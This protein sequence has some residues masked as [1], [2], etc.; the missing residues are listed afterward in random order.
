M[1]TYKTSGR[2]RR[3]L[4]LGRRWSL[5]G[6]WAALSF[7]LLPGCQ[8]LA[9]SP[10]E[11]P[12][13]GQIPLEA[14]RTRDQ[15]GAF[16]ADAQAAGET[17]DVKRGTL[18][19]VIGF[20][21]Q[22]VPARTAKLSFRTGGDVRTVYVRSGQAVKSGE[23]LAQLALDDEALRTAQTQATVAEL[24]YQ[25]QASRVEQL[26]QG[27]GAASAED[28]RANVAKARA[29]LLEAQV[30]RDVARSA[31][32]VSTDVQLAS[33]AVDQAKD[34]LANA[35]DVSRRTQETETSNAAVAVRT[36]QRRVDEANLR[37]ELLRAN[38][39]NAQ[40]SAQGQQ[41]QAQLEV[42]AAKD[43][44]ARAQ[45]MAG[46]GE[47]D[48]RAAPANAQAAVQAAQ[49][50]VAA[51]TLRLD[52]AQQ[53]GAPAN[54]EAAL[55]LARLD[56]AQA[57]AQRAQAQQ[58]ARPDQAAPPTSPNLA[59]EVR[60]SGTI[61]ALPAPTPAVGPSPTPG[62]VLD[63]RS[64]D[65]RVAAAAQKVEALSRAPQ[66]Q[67]PGDEQQLAQLQL[68]A[69]QDQLARAQAA[70]QQTAQRT[71]Q[72]DQTGL[73]AGALAVRA[74]DRR[75]QDATLRLQ[76]VQATASPTADQTANDPEIRL[77]ELNLAQAQDDLTAVQAQAN[78]AAQ[79]GS[80]TGQASAA[81]TAFAVRAA[82]RKL[83]EATLKLQQAGA[84]EQSAQASGD[85]QQGVADLRVAAAQ[86][87]LQAAQA[88]LN[89]VQSGSGSAEALRN[90][91]RRAELLQSE[92][93]AA[94]SQAQPVITL[95]AP[96]DGT[97]ASVDVTENQT[98]DP[99][100]TV[101]RL[102]DP[103]RLSVLA[104][105]SQFEVSRLS[106]D[107]PVM[108]DFPG[109][110]SE[111]VKGTIVDLST[112]AVRDGDRTGFPV[113][114][115]LDQMP[116]AVR[117]GMTA[118][119]NVAVKADNVLYVPAAA[120]HMVGASPM[121]TRV[122]PDGSRQD[123]QVVLGATFGSNIEIVSGLKEQDTIAARSLAAAPG[124]RPA[125]N[126]QAQVPTGDAV[127]SAITSDTARKAQ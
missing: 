32:P 94:R 77:A 27:G 30:A 61:I 69:A 41:Q 1:A 62:A 65:L 81:S 126:P 40:A 8:F 113:R 36:A 87:S 17:T 108:I 104:S 34:E 2:S 45:L 127:V 63:L 122:A 76:Q 14:G 102:D 16:G 116:G 5:L 91:E 71:E 79:G 115:D 11:P 89:E 24:A 25:S 13:L 49:R 125:G 86:G 22:V 90:E 100:T 26:K 73:S 72:D 52:M 110:T 114:I 3:Y 66:Q 10:A 117:A 15:V 29:A 70:A 50:E 39:A 97:V 120:I 82:E 103:G 59:S 78:L 88:H 21:G 33:L 6:V 23:P 92:A 75:L 56:L 124:P 43:E 112:A 4:K 93:L 46:R 80:A 28:A 98:V 109:V 38:R 101:V 9:P 74:A 58:N 53:S 19:D 60:P 44:L 47:E 85:S 123:V 42:D 12:T 105:A 18:Q 64:A 51:A 119:V 121:V 95:T 35:Q 67:G 118:T 106:T 99:R 84:T 68:D 48:A 55:Q 107:Q 57:Q 31:G 7:A 54:R 96:F 83:S 20:S 37:L 111:S